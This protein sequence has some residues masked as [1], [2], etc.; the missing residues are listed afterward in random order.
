M[1]SNDH[2]DGS[3]RACVYTYIRVCYKGDEVQM[4]FS[5]YTQKRLFAAILLH[6]SNMGLLA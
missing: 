3:A 4:D 1:M 2:L 6:T 5:L